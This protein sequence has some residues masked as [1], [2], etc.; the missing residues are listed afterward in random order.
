MQTNNNCN[1]NSNRNNSYGI[2]QSNHELSFWKVF[3]NRFL[4]KKILNSKCCLKSK[5]FKNITSIK[6][7]L[8]NKNYQFL[9]YKIIAKEKLFYIESDYI[10]E[11]YNDGVPF[12]I[13]YKEKCLILPEITKEKNAEFLINYPSSKVKIDPY[14]YN[15]KTL[16]NVFLKNYISTSLRYTLLNNF[17]FQTYYH[18]DFDDCLIS[19]P[20]SSNEPTS[21]ESILVY[22]HL[23]FNSLK[24]EDYVQQFNCDIKNNKTIP[25]SIQIKINHITL[26][27]NKEA[28]IKKLF[29]LLVQETQSLVLH[30]I[31]IKKYSEP[32]EHIHLDQVDNLLLIYITN[33]FNNKVLNLLLKKGNKI[34]SNKFNYCEKN[35]YNKYMIKLY[36]QNHGYSKDEVM[37]FIRNYTEQNLISIGVLD[38][39]LSKLILNANTKEIYSEFLNNIFTN[40]NNRMISRDAFPAEWDP[41]ISSI[42]DI[43][44]YTRIKDRSTIDW[45]A[46]KNGGCSP[47]TK[48]NL[49]IK[50]NKNYIHFEALELLEYARYKFESTMMN[51]L[52]SNVKE[53]KIHILRSNNN[54][55]SFVD[56]LIMSNFNDNTQLFV[57]FFEKRFRFG[58]NGS[59][60]FIDNELKKFEAPQRYSHIID[61]SKISVI[62]RAST[63]EIVWLFIRLVESGDLHAIQY[64]IDNCSDQICTVTLCDNSL[65]SSLYS[66]YEYEIVIKLIQL[67]ITN[68]N[69]YK[70]SKDV[71]SP[72]LQYLFNQVIRIGDI[73][74]DQIIEAHQLITNFAE[75]EHGLDYS[76]FYLKVLSPMASSFIVDICI[77]GYE[78]FYTI[79]YS[80][81]FDPDILTFDYFFN[82]NDNVDKLEFIDS[83]I[84]AIVNQAGFSKAPLSKLSIL[85]E[86]DPP[87]INLFINLFKKYLEYKKANPTPTKKDYNSFT[88]KQLKLMI[89][90]FDIESFIQLED[91]LNTYG[92]KPDQSIYILYEE[93]SEIKQNHSVRELYQKYYCSN[94]NIV[95]WFGSI[96]YNDYSHNSIANYLLN[97]Y[98]DQ[99]KIYLDYYIITD[100]IKTINF[101]HR[102]LAIID[103]EGGKQPMIYKKDGDNDHDNQFS[104]SVIL[105]YN[106]E[107]YNFKELKIELEKLGYQFKTRSDTEVV[108]LSYIEWGEECLSKF[109]G[110]FAFAIYD[111]RKS[112]LFLARDRMGVK[113]LYYTIIPDDGNTIVFGS[114]IKVLLTHPSVKPYVDN[115]GLNN[116]FTMGPI[117]SPDHCIYRDIKS[118]PAGNYITFE[119]IQNEKDNIKSSSLSIFQEY[120]NFKMNIKEYWNLKS[121]KHTDNLGE[122]TIKVLKLF[123]QSV[124]KQLVS[125][126]PIGFLLSGGL[127]SSLIVAITSKDIRPNSKLNTFSL[128]FENEESDFK[129]DY[130]R[131]DV[132]EPFSKL[133]ATDCSTNHKTV[134]INSKNNLYDVN[135][136]NPLKCFDYPSYGNVD[137]SMIQL[138]KEIKKDRSNCKVILSG[139]LSDEVFS[140]YS[141]FHDEKVISNDTIPTLVG[142]ELYNDYNLY[143]KDEFLEKLDYKNFKDRKF[144]ELLNQVPY[145]M[146]DNLDEENQFQR[147]Q[148]ILSYFFIKYY[149]HYL[150]ERKDRC[151]M[152]NSI[153]VRVP[154]GDQDLVEYC[155]NIPFEIKSL[156]NIEKGILRRSIGNLLPKE[157]QYRRKSAY[158]QSCDINFFYHLCDQMEL[159]LNDSK[160]PIHQFIKPEP[161]YQIIKNKLNIDNPKKERKLFEHLLLTNQWIKEYKII[162]V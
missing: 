145:L 123:K 126:E 4:L 124:E 79:L 30:A 62:L 90:T 39:K 138:F 129:Q 77:Q 44:V 37:K 33:T 93:V 73:K 3:N 64:L 24:F 34:D 99:L 139:E 83:T 55:K 7:M 68:F 140:G 132:D 52:D 133:V 161:I 159:V 54:L 36:E 60:E 11:V 152:S 141:W 102:R 149:G 160:S 144:S 142:V 6:S 74:K 61:S 107:L 94:A 154:F 118:V 78:E 26:S 49:N 100:K 48:D 143:L 91:I 153:E 31:Y 85:L 111:E 19:S 29:K 9:K 58:P 25:L 130:L 109:N 35:A 10:E 17:Q 50:L 1:D 162:F 120:S 112:S 41:V 117:K 147:K 135:V 81:Q 110:V 38:K 121:F 137:T 12:S 72:A 18:H 97:K 27:N 92:D 158:P 146:D 45:L 69:N 131:R 75:L 5:K 40:T 43:E 2:I 76:Y 8:R 65:N 57:D 119:K 67:F 98:S 84:T 113:P 42:Y 104:F 80:F 53:K 32:I 66:Y 70:I 71:L 148:R 22:F 23:Y 103:L 151:S 56:D 13:S 89:H 20:H 88:T 16:I 101:S 127:D 114:E 125:D 59:I 47:C 157:V 95:D 63:N 96:L 86:H 87:R 155:W 150:L 82:Q 46:N 128:S 136:Y 51:I 21:I 116:L 105:T 122:T 108:L 134:I 106:G 115:E 15:K 28:S 14:G 156:D